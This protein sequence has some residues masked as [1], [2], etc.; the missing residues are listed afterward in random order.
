MP[1]EVEDLVRSLY[2]LGLV[3][4]EIARHA[5]DELGSQGFLALAVIQT[6]GPLRVGEVADRLSI[7][8]SVASR[9][10]NAL[11]A[12]GYA[13]RERDEKDGR[14]HRISATEAGVEVLTRCHRR[15]VEA[16]SE[17][18]EDWSASDI[19]GLA[20]RL[21]LL[22]EDF[23]GDRAHP[24]GEPPVS[25]GPSALKE[26]GLRRMLVAVD[27]SP[28]SDLALAAAIT[29]AQ[30]DNASLTLITVEPDLATTPAHWAIMSAPP[31]EMQADAHRAAERML[32]EALDRLPEDVPATTILRFGKAGPEI[33]SEAATGKYDAIL[34]GA[35]GVGMVGSLLGSVSQYVLHHAD[36]AVF[37]THAPPD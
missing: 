33:V 13:R 6:N 5:L 23:S 35:R 22:R 21:D 8:I 10:V 14:A 11:I 2:R 4:R 18:L 16:F 32:E 17:A 20:Q 15:L 29:V 34:V 25:V 30:R 31:P 1:E 9:Q 37:V 19:A 27:G 12:A 3:Q 36:I 7:D 26:L 24:R 28:N